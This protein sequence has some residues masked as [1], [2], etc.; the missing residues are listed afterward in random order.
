MACKNLNGGLGPIHAPIIAAIDQLPAK[1]TIG[2]LE[3]SPKFRYLGEQATVGP[4]PADGYGDTL[5]LTASGNAPTIVQLPHPYG[6]MALTDE[7]TPPNKCWESTTKYFNLGTLKDILVELVIYTRGW[8]S[9]SFSNGILSAGAG[10]KWFDILTESFTPLNL[11]CL[12]DDGPSSVSINTANGS[13]G[14]SQVHIA[15]FFFDASGNAQWYLE[16]AASGSPVAVSGLG[17]LT[18]DSVMALGGRN[19]GSISRGIGILAASAWIE[20]SG[21]LP[22]IGAETAALAKERAAIAMGQSLAHSHGALTPTTL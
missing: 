18:I 14:D 4:W 5:Q 10:G 7:S 11:R 17:A 3:S 20:D 19:A 2:G 8:L 13:I 16:G 21:W 22:A 6:K 12:V 9:G 1:V 15:H